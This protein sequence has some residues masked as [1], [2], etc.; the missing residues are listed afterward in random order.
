MSINIFK[1]LHTPGAQEAREIWAEAQRWPQEQRPLSLSA[2]EIAIEGSADVV[3]V[4]GEFPQMVVACEKAQRLQQLKAD[5]S[6][7]TIRIYE[8]G[9]DRQK[10]SSFS[11]FNFGSITIG[12]GRISIGGR[13]FT[14]T[15]TGGGQHDAGR[16]IVFLV[17]PRLQQ[18]RIAGSADAWLYDLEEEKFGIAIAG[19]GDVSAKGSTTRLNLSIAGSGDVYARDLC[20]QEAQI[21]IAGSGDVQA[22]ALQKV[23][24]TIAGSGDVRI[25]G[26]PPVRS[27]SISGSGTLRFRLSAL[28]PQA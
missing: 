13:D 10:G 14:A 2:T 28:R 9:P 25:F 24:V 12:G 5:L 23:S 17:M 4:R 11:S 6:G 18:I 8:D 7:H 20:C 27:E 3:M 15:A 16:A 1:D 26:N 21:S 22:T 19:S